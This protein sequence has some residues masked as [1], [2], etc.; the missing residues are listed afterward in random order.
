MTKKREH[1]LFYAGT[2]SGDSVVFGRK[3]AGHIF[4]ALR[5]KAGDEISATDGKGNVFR[6]RLSCFDGKNAEAA[7]YETV[8]LPR[9]APQIHVMIGL[10]EKSAMENA[11]K[12]LAALGAA[13]VTP[14]ICRYCQNPWWERGWERYH[15][16]FGRTIAAAAKQSLNPYFME[17]KPPAGFGEA[18]E[19]AAEMPLFYADEDAEEGFRPDG[20]AIRDR[21]RITCLAGPPGGF[22]PEEASLLRKKGAVALRLA[23]YRLKTELAAVVMVGCMVG[24]MHCER[25]T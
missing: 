2:V 19:G 5:M 16:R 4:S 12:G 24:I 1:H 14:L 21:D 11:L 9:P 13:Q 3:E 6:C 18:L 15:M 10:P 23:R 25:E 7:I 22:A 8:C 20:E 17:L